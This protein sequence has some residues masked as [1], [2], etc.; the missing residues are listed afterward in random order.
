M[1]QIKRAVERAKATVTGEHLR[2]MAAMPDQFAPPQEL[3]AGLQSPARTSASSAVESQSVIPS[4]YSEHKLDWRHLE[5]R[6]IVGHNV[7]DPRS[8]AFDILRT[9]V[10]QAMD[11]KNWQFLAITS[12]TEGCGKTVTAINLA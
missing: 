4:L 5:Q 6:R 3:N 12:P 11:Q 9:Q 8:K 2:S 10:L 1:E 7:T